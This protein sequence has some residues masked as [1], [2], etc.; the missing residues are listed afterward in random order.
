MPIETRGIICNS[1]IANIFLN[2]SFVGTATVQMKHLRRCIVWMILYIVMLGLYIYVR[3]CE[4]NERN[5]CHED[6]SL[7]RD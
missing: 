3:M 2:S 7:S 6:A 5:T 4:N 1:C